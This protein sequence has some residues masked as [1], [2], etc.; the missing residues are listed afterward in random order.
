MASRSFKPASYL[1]S[2]AQRSCSPARP[3]FTRTSSGGSVKSDDGGFVGTMRGLGLENQRDGNVAPGGIHTHG[4][5]TSP[6]RKR[7]V[8]IA[9][10]LPKRN[11]LA[12]TPLTAR[13]ELPG[14]YFPNHDVEAEYRPHGF[15]SSTMHRVQSPFNKSG[16]SSRASSVGDDTA[17]KLTMQMTPLLAPM[18]PTLP[19]PLVKPMGKYH[20]ANYK[21]LDSTEVSTPTSVPPIRPPM[22]PS[23]LTMPSLRT[24]KSS[25]G[26]KRD[27]SDVKKKLKQYQQDMI[28]Q[29]KA[30]TEK[31]QGKILEEKKKKPSSPRLEP[32][33]GTM[34]PGAITPLELEEAMISGYMD[35]RR[36]SEGTRIDNGESP[37]IYALG[38][39]VDLARENV[40]RI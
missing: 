7:S 10:E 39:P 29:A 12:Y 18:S 33:I 9:I 28:A 26:H 4:P 20:P 27:S 13:G 36:G 25:Q 31:T 34:S 37:V 35:V 19:E 32:A 40:E 6:T 3:G 2:A 14:G 8:P 21:S 22:P 1:A 38:T 11:T 24:R 5:D 30:A 15:G 16:F 23:N 17:P